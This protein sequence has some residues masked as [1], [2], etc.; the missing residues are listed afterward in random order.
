MNDLLETLWRRHQNPWS[1]AFRLVFFL[2]L[3]L[4]L[5]LHALW[6]VLLAVVGLGTS[7]FWFPEPSTP[8]DFTADALAGERDWLAEPLRGRK[9]IEVVFGLAAFIL[10]L[11]AMWT[12]QVFFSLL[13]VGGIVLFKSLFVLRVA[14]E[15]RRKREE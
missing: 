1:W 3:S 7:W 8:N 14:R 10:Y 9:L 5:W 4:G 12:N 11:W 2:M 6:V 15:A 13:M